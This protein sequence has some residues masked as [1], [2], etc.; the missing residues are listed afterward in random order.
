MLNLKFSVFKIHPDFARSS[1]KNLQKSLA[2]D[3]KSCYRFLIEIFLKFTPIFC[4]SE[5]YPKI[6]NFL[7]VYS[8]SPKSCLKFFKTSQLNFSPIQLWQLSSFLLV[9]WLHSVVTQ[10]RM[11]NRVHYLCICIRSHISKFQRL[12]ITSTTLQLIV[13]MRWESYCVAMY[14]Y[15]N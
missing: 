13:Y 4:D 3:F 11:C 6:M 7:K 5:F 10:R 9:P 14:D 2:I 12:T 8:N 1:D 15:D